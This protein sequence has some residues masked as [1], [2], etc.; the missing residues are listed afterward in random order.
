MVEEEEEGGLEDDNS[1]IRN[2][3]FEGTLDDGED[4]QNDGSLQMSPGVTNAYGPPPKKPTVENGSRPQS[5][6][7]SHQQIKKVKL[8][9][10]SSLFSKI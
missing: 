7:K 10:R 5:H 6:K 8:I 1:E 2:S 4:T 9:S 3:N